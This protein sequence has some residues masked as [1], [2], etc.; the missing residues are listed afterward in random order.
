MLKFINGLKAVKCAPIRNAKGFTLMEILIVLV[1][2]AVIVGLAVPIYQTTAKKT[3]KA[4]ALNLLSALRQSE[5]RY[6]QSRSPRVYT[7][8]IA[9]LDFDPTQVAG[10]SHFGFAITTGAGLFTATATGNGVGLATASD[11]VTLTEAGT[12]GGTL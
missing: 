4:E 12:V 3:Y 5:A 11:T 6:Y 7:T 9:Q 2:L 10:T 1:V 8:T